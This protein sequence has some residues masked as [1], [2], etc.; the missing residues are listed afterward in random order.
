[1]T[2][3]E[4]TPNNVDNMELCNL[5]NILSSTKNL[6]NT[7]YKNVRFS[8]VH[9]ERELDYIASDNVVSDDVVSDDFVKEYIKTTCSYDDDQNNDQ[10]NDQ[11]DDEN[12]EY[13]DEKK[14]TQCDNVS[15]GTSIEM[16]DKFL[17]IYNAKHG[18]NGSMFESVDPKNPSDT[19]DKMELFYEHMATHIALNAENPDYIDIYEPGVAMVNDASYDVYA[20]VIGK[21]LSVK[22]ISLSFVS[23][24]KTGVENPIDIGKVWSIIKL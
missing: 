4:N 1:M 21:E 8:E 7:Q 22:Y 14:Q 17:H 24:L 13:C 10:Y 9:N 12:N 23:L 15:P 20:M 6:S 11:N 16:F 3:T 5:S 19:N 2:D 18:M